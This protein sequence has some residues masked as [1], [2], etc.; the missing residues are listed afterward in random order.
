MK[1]SHTSAVCC[2]T[3]GLFKLQRKLR[4]KGSPIQTSYPW[5]A[6]GHCQLLY[7]TGV[8]YECVRDRCIIRGRIKR[9]RS[10]ARHKTNNCVTQ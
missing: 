8:S 10:E 1:Q 9:D 5:K 2:K 7:E 4:I 3:G 6:T